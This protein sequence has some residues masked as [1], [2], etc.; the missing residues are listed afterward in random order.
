MS[1]RWSEVSIDSKVIE[2]AQKNDPTAF[3]IIFK[4]FSS[5]VIERAAA[6]T[7]N[8]QDAEDIGQVTF[9]KA[10]KGI[11]EY[12]GEGSFGAWL[13][14][15]EDN[16]ITDYHRR[17]KT[18]PLTLFSE[19]MLR[20]AE[21]PFD[22]PDLETPDLETAFIRGQDVR[23]I[24]TSIGIGSLTERQREVLTLVY[25]GGLSYKEVARETGLTLN[26]AKSIVHR[27]IATLRRLNQS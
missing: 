1:N 23:E 21:G 4:T 11:R 27:A 25:G 16:N 26:G 24:S 19:E 22:T 7:G 2:A 18:R 15:I 20:V 10:F 3:E 12:R 6:R 17:R 9:M 13:R 14:Q 8:H 5:I